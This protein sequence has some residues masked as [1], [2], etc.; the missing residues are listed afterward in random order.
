MLERIGKAAGFE[1]VAVDIDGDD[2]L[3]KRYMFEIPVVTVDGVP[4]ARWPFSAEMLEEAVVGALAG[5]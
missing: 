1:P 3:A 4:V 2:G 5:R